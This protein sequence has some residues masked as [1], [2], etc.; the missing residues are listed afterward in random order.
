MVVVQ[1]VVQMVGRNPEEI[2]YADVFARSPKRAWAQDAGKIWCRRFLAQKITS[3]CNRNAQ[4]HELTDQG[5]ELAY[6]N[7]V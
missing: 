4:R 2:P 5:D 1:M 7:A 3:G 6:P